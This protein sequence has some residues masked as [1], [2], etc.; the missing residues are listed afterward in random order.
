MKTR[1]NSVY[2]L[3]IASIVMVIISAG[4]TYYST[5]EKREATRSVIRSYQ[6]IQS[7]TQLFSILK[8][9]ETG[10]RGYIITGDSTFLEPYNEAKSDLQS[11]K[12]TLRNL[13]GKNTQQS[14]LLEGKVLQAVNRKYNDLENSLAV[15]KN[16][17]S[18]SASRRVSTR[19]GKAH[20][21]TLRVLVQ[22]LVQREKALLS[23][24]D[25]KLE[26]NTEMEDA[27]R[28]Y[29][30]AL[31]GLTS[32]VALVTII[33]KQ[34]SNT[35]LLDRLKS[36]NEE[37]E[38]KVLER[39]TQL[40]EANQ[41]KDHFLGIA[42]HD[43]KV[44][45]SGILRLIELMKLNT[46]SASD[47]EYLTY[48]HESCTGMQQL[49]TNLL[50]INRIE[51]RVMTMAKHTVDLNVLLSKL[52]NEFSYPCKKK[53]ITLTI[54]KV[55]GTIQTDQ[56]ALFRILENLL[57][58]AIK[59]SLPGKEVNLHVTRNEQSIKFEIIDQG[60]GIPKEDIPLLFGRFQKLTNKPTGGENSTGLGLSIAKELTT[61]LDGD[62]SV[63]SSVGEGSVFT[64]VIPV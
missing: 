52:E 56:D 53:N 41:A 25:R 32:L 42:S 16:F 31:I 60:P 10:Q 35:E 20:M 62:I 64:V 17:G 63:T 38:H 15:F 23:E 24:Q 30:F 2:L 12:D 29:S 45:I 26:A 3:L 46:R 57:S 44:P 9:M 21:D 33:R 11:E 34:R 4:I 19:I 6:V 61:S 39:T 5:L 7:S 59:F 49:I 58:N 50:D 18:D 40:V 55:Q 54:D 43:L 28:F 36:A 13:I 48:M 14:I 22:D 27:I 47:T 51:Q 37:L 8:D 1:T